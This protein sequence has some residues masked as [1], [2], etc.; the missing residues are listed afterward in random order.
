M[1]AVFFVK[2]RQSKTIPVVNS[3]IQGCFCFGTA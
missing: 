3:P 1:E 2:V